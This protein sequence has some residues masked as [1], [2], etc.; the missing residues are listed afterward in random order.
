MSKDKIVD[1]LVYLVKLL[2][3]PDGEISGDMFGPVPRTRSPRER[4]IAEE[5][6]RIAEEIKTGKSVRRRRC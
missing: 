4:H 3:I 6:A 2:R 5:L 1:R